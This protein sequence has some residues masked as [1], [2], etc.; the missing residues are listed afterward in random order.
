MICVQLGEVKSGNK[1]TVTIR[2][3]RYFGT[4]CLHDI[5]PIP[6]LFTMTSA[7]TEK[8]SSKFSTETLLLQIPP[9]PDLQWITRL[10]SKYPGLK[11]RW[12]PL[13]WTPVDKGSEATDLP[14]ETWEGVTM[15]CLFL[16]HPAHLMSK[17]RYV[18]LTSAG[19]DKWVEH[20]MYK[21]PNV[22]FCTANGVHP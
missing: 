6:A 16:P 12:V 3:E 10:E 8:L 7:D 18:Q 9:E 13:R 1:V 4:G 19:V 20:E 11:V 14:P 5:K 21:N 2:I 15:A 17:V 22:V